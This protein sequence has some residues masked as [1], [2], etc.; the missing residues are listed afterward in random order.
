MPRPTRRHLVKARRAGPIRLGCRAGCFR[1]DCDGIQDIPPGW[2]DV[3][4]IQSLEDS[5]ATYDGPNDPPE[6]RGY[7][8]T[9]WETHLGLCPECGGVE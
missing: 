2:R 3:D 9:D 7:S 5:M 1:G 4:E 8:V 6:P